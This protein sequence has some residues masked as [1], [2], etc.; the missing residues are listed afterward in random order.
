M[1]GHDRRSMTRRVICC[2]FGVFL[3]CAPL[4]VWAQRAPAPPNR[5]LQE[6]KK[7]YKQ[8][9]YAEIVHKLERALS[10][11]N[12]TPRQLCEIYELMGTVHVILGN[13]DAAVD[14]FNE[15]LNV[16]PKY[17][18]DS[19]LS[20]KILSIYRRVKS[21]FVPKAAVSFEGRPSV[22]TTPGKRP[23]V[24]VGVVDESKA[25]TAVEIWCRR[26]EKEEFKK[27]AMAPVGRGRYGGSLPLE[28]KSLPAVGVRVEYVIVARGDKGK[29]LGVL[30]SM[31]NPLSFT[32]L[33]A[34]AAPST[35]GPGI[36]DDSTPWYGSWWFWTAM[37]VV[38]AGA[39]VGIYLGLSSGGTDVPMGSLG[40]YT[41]D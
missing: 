26:S 28:M 16:D 4:G 23:W 19:S 24:E 7:L 18:L 14:A 33:P 6:A 27:G 20:P 13:E 2:A 36:K 10:V 11:P 32:V 34:V 35:Q 3:L 41:L 29:T 17:K 30:G 9:R 31:E 25:L 1:I 40:E 39:G 5:Y 21:E 15:L 12:N 38:A 8:L 22:R 37:G